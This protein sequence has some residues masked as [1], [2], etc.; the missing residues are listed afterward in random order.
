MTMYGGVRRTSKE[1]V[2]VGMRAGIIGVSLIV[3]G[4][5]GTSSIR[6]EVHDYLFDKTVEASG[7]CTYSWFFLKYLNE[8]YIRSD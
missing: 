2:P 8:R 6:T 7:T 4:C 5:N 1:G 3:N